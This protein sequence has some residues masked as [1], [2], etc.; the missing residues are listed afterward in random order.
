MLCKHLLPA[1]V[2]PAQWLGRVVRPPD[3]GVVPLP[4]VPVLKPP[5]HHAAAK[6]ASIES[7]VVNIWLLPFPPLGWTEV[8]V[9]VDETVGAEHE[10]P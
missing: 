5:A 3:A 7:D 10:G 8:A 4:C 1:G 9:V 2:Q 6:E